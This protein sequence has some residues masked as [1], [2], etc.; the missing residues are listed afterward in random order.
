MAYW[1]SIAGHRISDIDYETIEIGSM[2]NTSC[3]FRDTVFGTGMPERV[4]P[5]G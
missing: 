1:N 3:D 5:F 4:E 2:L